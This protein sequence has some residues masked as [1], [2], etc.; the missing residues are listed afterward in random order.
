MDTINDRYILIADGGSTKADWRLLGPDGKRAADFQTP[1][2]NPEILT[3]EQIRRRLQKIQVFLPPA[4][5]IGQVFFYGAGCGTPSAKEKLRKLFREFFPAADIFVEEDM[6]GA[7]RATAGKNEGIVAILGTG[8][9]ACYYDGTNLFMH[10]VSLGYLIM[11]EGSGNY[12]GKFLLRDY[13]YGLM[14]A[15]L[16]KD[17]AW[18]FPLDPDHVKAQ[19]YHSDAPNVYLASFM[20]F[21]HRWRHETYIRDLLQRGFS[22]FIRLRILPY[23]AAGRAPLYFVGSVAHFFADE[24][25][26]AAREA[27]LKIEKII[28]RPADEL[29]RFHAGTLRD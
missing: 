29:A 16:R 25:Q 28:Q 2:L 26:S 5:H 7:A 23:P 18:Q 11:D 15:H 12:F 17:F 4:S 13:Y 9:N 19:L 24:L 20:P 8:S 3:D 14:P 1:G 21:M 27:G 10:N 22:D 6:L